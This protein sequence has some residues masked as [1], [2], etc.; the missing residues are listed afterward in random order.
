[1]RLLG[2]PIPRA[3]ACTQAGVRGKGRVLEVAAGTGL[4]TRAIASVAREVVATD[5]AEAMVELLKARVAD[6][7]NVRV[8][9]ADLYAL[10]TEPGSFDAVVAAN[11]LHLVPDLG[12]AL[13]SLKSALVPGGTLIAPT[14]CHDQTRLSR[15][16]SRVAHRFGF[17]SHRR[18]DDRSL[19]AAVERAGFRVLRR[20]VIDG[21]FPIAFVEAVREDGP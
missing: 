20:D 9:Q 1:M 6:L 5:Y 15:T 12:G 11:V 14:Y 8:Q 19:T 17:P 4:F 2:G 7:P 10:P 21:L 13:A 3:V 18:F 16:I